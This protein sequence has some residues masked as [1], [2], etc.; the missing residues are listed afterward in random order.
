[1]TDEDKENLEAYAAMKRALAGFTYARLEGGM[2]VYMP[3][4]EDFRILA[5]RLAAEQ[6]ATE[7]KKTGSALP[8]D[9]STPRPE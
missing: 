9:L 5:D 7:A 3:S 6:K 8:D 4:K 1:M 2:R